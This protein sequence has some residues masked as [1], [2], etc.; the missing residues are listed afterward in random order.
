MSNIPYFMLIKNSKH[1]E[2]IRERMVQRYYQI[3]NYSQ[4][5]REYG[6]KRQGLSSGLKDLKKKELRV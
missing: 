4:V 2:L 6:T 5:A 1:P 3:L